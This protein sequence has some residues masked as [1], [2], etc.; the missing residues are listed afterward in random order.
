MNLEER[1]KL[2]MKSIDE[3][4]LVGKKVCVD[5]CVVIDGR[6][7][8]LIEK[9]KLKDAT[10]VIPEAVVSEL[11]FQ[12]NRGRE[13][14]YKGIEELRKLVEKANEYNIKVEYY[15]ERPTREEIFLAKSGEIDA[16]IRKVAKETNSI[17]LTSDWIQYNLA[18]AQGIEA[19]YLE[20]VEE[21]VELVLNKYFDEE[22]MS[23][24]LKEG[25]LPYAKKG[26]PGAVKLV[27]I[28]DKEL[29]KEEMEDIIDNIIKYAEQNNGFFEIQRKGATVIQLGNIRI[30]IARPPFSE[31]LEVTAVRPVVKASL[32][33]YELSDKLLERLKERAEGIFVSGP[34]GSG[35]CLPR[36]TR[37]LLPDGTFKNIEELKLGDYVLSVGL[38]EIMENP[39]IKTYKRKESRLIKIKTRLGRELILTERHPILCIKDGFVGWREVKNLDV[40][41]VIGV[42]KSLDIEGKDIEL[43]IVDL[44]K[45]IGEGNK[46]YAILENGDEKPVSEVNDTDKIKYIYYKGNNNIKSR[47]IK[48]NIKLDENFAELLGLLWAEG[49]GGNLEF[50]NLDERLIQHYKKLMMEVFDIKENEFYFADRG[51]LRIRNPK[52]I[53]LVLKALGYPE[54]KK[55]KTLKVPGIIF[56][57]NK[58]I[59]SAFIR[60]VFEGDGYIGERGIEIATASKEFANGIYY[61]LI[62]L[63]ITPFLKEKKIGDNVYYRILIQNSKD[64]N[65]FYNIIKPR[66]KVAGFER[67]LN[68]ESNPNVGTVPVGNVLKELYELLGGYIDNAEK[69]EYSIE[70]LE[71]H[72]NILIDMYKNYV[73]YKE[74]IEA[75]KHINSTLK[76]WKDVIKRLDELLKTVN[77]QKFCKEHNIDHNAFSKY[78]SNKRKPTLKTIIKY[79]EE[80]NKEFDLED[81]LMNW[82]TTYEQLNEILDKIKDAPF[83]KF[84]SE[85]LSPD[86][87]RLLFKEKKLPNLISLSEYIDEICKEYYERLNKIETCLSNLMAILNKNI[88]W[89]KIVEK[90]EIDYNDFVYD[91]EVPYHNFIINETPIIVHNSTFVAALAEFYKNQGKVVKTME[92]PRDLQVSKEITQY[93]PLEGDMEKT[94]DILLLVRPD[95]TIYDEVRKTRDFEIFADMRMAGVGMVGVV[96]ASKPIDAIQRLIG[97]VELGVIPQVVDTVIFIKDGKIQK[98]YEIDFT[99]KVPYGMVEEDLA[100]PVIEVKDFETGRVE[101]EIYTYGEQVVVMPIKDEEGKKAP[102]YGYAEEKLEEILKKLLPRKAKPM[103]KV[104]GDNSIDLIVPEKYVGAIIGKGGREISKLEDMLGLK[105]SVKEKEKEEEKDMEKIYR[106]YEYVNELEATKI[107][108]TDKYVVVDVG[109]D[110]AGENIKIYID[111]KLLTT[112]TVRN[113][114]TVRINKKTKVGKEILKAIDEGRDVYVDLQ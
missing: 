54:S 46:F 39:I 3:L 56:K 87:K 103:V 85:V 69:N 73:A 77:K 100:R 25:C 1:K 81:T 91:I 7:T 42:V 89:D 5:T 30:S 57:S 114:G 27:P 16:M 21:E 83:I 14:G 101:Y 65:K 20:S 58:N 63:G 45:N 62:R 55:S 43:N 32:D 60:G 6:I 12:A 105:I 95:Y 40:G 66:F 4:D 111:G 112:V 67:F 80:F 13:I 68:K 99:V 31:A 18:K 50:N 88:F 109:E 78:L 22:T 26:K 70:R 9:G 29:T 41:D 48:P 75:L 96:H 110:F 90:E 104:T 82:K 74:K 17:L 97:R 72:L 106:R 86:M 19:Y 38:N 37:V 59:I 34:P 51:R 53:Y 28:G 2:E 33:D 36:G 107:Y 79:L 84:K 71:M 92:S 64:I 102:I 15:G 52:T 94:C 10:I 98:V 35:K 8:E 113:D 24:H 44:I 61:L 47:K 108:E 49:S 93:A 76:D 23:V 11:E